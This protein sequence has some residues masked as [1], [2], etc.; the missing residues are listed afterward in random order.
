M[1]G[2]DHQKLMIYDIAVPTLHRICPK[3]QP[4][5]WLS[6]CA[7]ACLVAGCGLQDAFSSPIH[8]REAVAHPTDRADPQAVRVLQTA[9]GMEPCAA[10]VAE[11][12]L[13]GELKELHGKMLGESG[14]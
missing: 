4:S 8:R 7:R 5:P 11:G 2:I 3:L 12:L 9:G 6:R 1:G 10:T 13:W 14:C